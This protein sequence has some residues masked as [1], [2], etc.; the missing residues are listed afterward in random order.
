MVKDN[1]FREDLLYRINTVQI[2]IPPLRDRGDDIVHLAEHFLLKYARKYNKLQSRFTAG[3]ILK[4]KGHTWPGNVRELEHAVEKAVILSEGSILD[5]EDFAF[6][7]VTGLKEDSLTSIED[8]E[9]YYII[10]S[11]EK[12]RGKLTKVAEDLNLSRQT[13]YR[14]I[15]KYGL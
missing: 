2:E 10:K 8:I 13:I 4:L 9:K 14:K 1:L 6:H 5:E 3:A 15:K 7:Q 12:N 11:L